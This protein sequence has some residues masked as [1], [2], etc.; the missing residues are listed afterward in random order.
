[1]ETL[2]PQ[3]APR[4]ALVAEALMGDFFWVDND[5]DW[6]F[7]CNPQPGQPLEI[8]APGIAIASIDSGPYPEG[9]HWVDI[10]VDFAGFQIE[11]DALFSDSTD[12]IASQEAMLAEIRE[13]VAATLTPIPSISWQGKSWDEII[14]N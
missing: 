4:L 10:V 9:G 6:I 11:L 8:L 7:G 2:L 13:I 3:L 1:M 12:A 14:A 5:E